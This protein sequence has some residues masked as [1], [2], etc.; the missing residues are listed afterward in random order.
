M[1]SENGL[2]AAVA[3]QPQSAHLTLGGVLSVEECA[4]GT[5]FLDLEVRSIV[6][7]W[8]VADEAL[9]ALGI[10]LYVQTHRAAPVARIDGDGFAL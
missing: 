9:V 7:I 10:I 6:I 1:F 4:V 3:S 2:A 5:L 8:C